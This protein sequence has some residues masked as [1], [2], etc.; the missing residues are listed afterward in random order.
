MIYLL[1]TLTLW[2][3]LSW[4]YFHA[5]LYP[6]FA[7]SLKI[8]RSQYWFPFL[9]FFFSFSWARHYAFP[10]SSTTNFIKQIDSCFHSHSIKTFLSEKQKG[11]G[12]SLCNIIWCGISSGESVNDDSIATS[13]TLDSKLLNTSVWLIQVLPF[14]LS[15]HTTTLFTICSKYLHQ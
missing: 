12:F 5:F 2:W 14:S 15:A 1:Y 11:G 7:L 13:L 10:S 6:C 4:F 3:V 9:H 8:S